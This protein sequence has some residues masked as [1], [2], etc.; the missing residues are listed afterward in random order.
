M[1][2]TTAVRD[3]FIN[4]LHAW[5]TSGITQA[6]FGDR[7]LDDTGANSGN[8]G[9]PVV[10]GNLALVSVVDNKTFEDIIRGSKTA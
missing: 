7:F 4:A 2:T 3:Q 5:L 6:P 1:S 9:R 8:R 10:G